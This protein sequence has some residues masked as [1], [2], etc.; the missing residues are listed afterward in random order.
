MLVGGVLQC[1]GLAFTVVEIVRTENREFPDR[2]H[3]VRRFTAKV[4]SGWRWP[5]WRKPETMRVSTSAKTGSMGAG[6]AMGG[7]VEVTTIDGA[8]VRARLDHLE[9]RLAR[10]EEVQQRRLDALRDSV[11]RETDTLGQRI[12]NLANDVYGA[13][14]E[15]RA[16]LEESLA[17][18]S[19]T[20]ARSLSEPSWRRSAASTRETPGAGI[21]P[22]PCSACLANVMKAT[23]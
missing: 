12:A 14:S 16:A 5:P 8:D 1:F 11:K 23:A 19:S 6:A 18:Q 7:A 3:R 21:S 13:Q 4:R 9:R 2:K 17:R 22:A 10:S 15:Q 20:R